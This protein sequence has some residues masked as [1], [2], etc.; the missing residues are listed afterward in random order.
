MHWADPVTSRGYVLLDV[1]RYIEKAIMVI[2]SKKGNAGCKAF[3]VQCAILLVDVWYGWL[4][5]DFR[6]WLAVTYLPMD[7]S[8]LCAGMLHAQVLAVR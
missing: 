5:S 3:G 1:V 6:Q 4:N 8:R 2:R 7:P